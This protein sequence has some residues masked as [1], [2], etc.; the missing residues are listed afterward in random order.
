MALTSMSVSDE[1]LVVGTKDSARRARSPLR[2]TGFRSW[3]G[4]LVKFL[5]QVSFEHEIEKL[6]T[7]HFL[8]NSWI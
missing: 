5:L 4:I 1:L 2:S 6:G 3:E 8:F 7:E